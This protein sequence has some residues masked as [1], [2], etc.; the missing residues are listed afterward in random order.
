MFYRLKKWQRASRMDKIFIA[1][2]DGF[3]IARLTLSEDQ[4]KSQSGRDKIRHELA[5]RLQIPCHYIRLKPLIARKYK[6]CPELGKN[7]LIDD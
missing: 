4:Y 7:I 1:R 5:K 2:V 6:Y 3:E